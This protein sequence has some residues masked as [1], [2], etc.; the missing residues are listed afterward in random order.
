[1]G[2]WAILLAKSRGCTVIATTRR[3]SKLKQL[4]KTVANHVLLDGD[5]VEQAIE[6]FPNG[7]DVVLELAGP[8]SLKSIVLPPLA[9]HGNVVCTGILDTGWAIPF[10]VPATIPPTRKL[11]FYSSANLNA[12]GGDDEGLDKIPG[13]LAEVIR[14]VEN[15]TYQPSVF[16][17]K[18]FNLEQ[19]GEAHEYMEDN[20]AV[21]KVVITIA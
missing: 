3:K 4:A 18:V 13:A 8:A 6:L 1:V 10:L 19:V 21:G 15:G 12:L 2:V 7:V 5:F 20:R 14:K 17:G 9:R 16:L 11:S